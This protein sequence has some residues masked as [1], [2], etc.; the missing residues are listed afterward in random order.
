MRLHRFPFLLK[1]YF[2]VFVYSLFS[3][4]P[5]VHVLGDSH[6]SFCFTHRYPVRKP[7]EKLVYRKQ[8]F[9]INWLGPVTMFRVGRDSLQFIDLKKLGVKE[10][11]S[12]IFSFGEIDVRCHIEKQSILQNRPF[13]QVVDML[14]ENYMAAIVAN[15]HQY[16]SL[17]CIVCTVVPPTDSNSN[18]KYPTYGQ[19]E[20]RIAITRYLNNKIK[21]A[22]PS[23][24]LQVLDIYSQLATTDGAL[25]KALSDG[26]V[27]IAPR[28]NNMIKNMLIHKEKKYF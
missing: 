20:T 1:Q 5:S 4:K 15:K 19:L 25:N 10:Q 16:N 12:V 24:G 22:C 26:S 11:D 18:K 21:E 27:H 7:L 9:Q 2:S 17:Q 23:H 6:A 28:H 3:K 13:E 8:L 14:V